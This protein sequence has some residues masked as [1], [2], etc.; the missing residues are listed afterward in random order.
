MLTTTA[1]LC[2]TQLLDNL[3]IY[4][5]THI[6]SFKGTYKG[7]K[8]KVRLNILDPCSSHQN[9]QGWNH[10]RPQSGQPAQ[11]RRYWQD[12]QR[13]DLG[14]GES[15]TYRAVPGEGEPD[16]EGIQSHGKDDH[17]EC[18]AQWRPCRM[19]ASLRVS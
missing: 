17:T 3:E 16:A 12:V 18:A 13:N 8:C 19:R 1:N 15:G 5:G 4:V 11:C 2:E 10:G 6:G 7:F 9:H 14:M